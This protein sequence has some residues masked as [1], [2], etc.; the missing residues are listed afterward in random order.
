MRA[1]FFAS[2]AALVTFEVLSVYLIMPMPGSQRLATLGL[3]Y[4][5]FRARWVVRVALLLLV[6]GASPAAWRAGKVASLIALLL[7]AGLV[8]F[9]NARLS[10]D[11]MFREPT[12]VAFAPRALNKVDEASVVLGVEHHGAFKAYP[13]RFLVYHHQVRD[14]VGGLQVM[15]TYCSVCRTGRVFEPV[16]GGHLET[17]RLV[18]MDH[19]NAMFEDVTTRSWWR[20]ATGEAVAGALAGTRLADVPSTQVQ[21][22]TWFELHPEATVL[23]L[24]E[25]SRD[26]VD[27]EGAFERGESK[28]AL[29]G[30]DRASWQDKSW[31]V[32]VERGAASKAY[33]WSLL[34][35]TRLINDTFDGRPIVLM[36]GNDLQSFAAFERPTAAPFELKGEWLEGAGGSYDVGGR[37]RA[38]PSRQLTRLAASQEFWHSWRT[39][40]PATERYAAP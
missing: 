13:I 5:L 18:G 21:L 23:Q 31:V 8:S 35:A 1:L 15:V 20:Q 6:A 40:H 11:A 4:A 3:A 9:V 27:L 19:F 34:K 28:G 10:A 7:T 14:T 16:V 39:F 12:V 24:D 26:Q 17:F 32:G 33:D 25:A 29:T 37:D 22:K 36:L 30:T 38:E 2:L